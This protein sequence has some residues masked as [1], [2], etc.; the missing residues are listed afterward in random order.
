MRYAERAFEGVPHPQD[1]HHL[2]RRDLRRGRFVGAA[3]MG[4]LSPPDPGLEPS[5]RK[6]ARSSTFWLAMVLAVAPVM[7]L[8]KQHAE[9]KKA[10]ED[11]A[12]L[13]KRTD[14]V[15][16][17]ELSPEQ[18]LCTGISKLCA[19]LS[20]WSQTAD[21]PERRAVLESMV[22]AAGPLQSSAAFMTG[23]VPALANVGRETDARCGTDRIL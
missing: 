13:A 1:E 10:G 17:L 14:L 6:K 15:A 18:A 5:R 9:R 2:R 16:R 21:C 11:Y 19:L 23:I 12:M 7:S 8:W 3:A 20:Q 22:A 4:S